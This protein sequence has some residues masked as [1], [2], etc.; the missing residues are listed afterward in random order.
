MSLCA[1]CGHENREGAR[2]CDACG[3]ALGGPVAAGE[4]RKTVTVLFSDVTGSTALGEQLDP[5]S[6]RRVMARYFELARSVIERH[7]GSVEKFIGDAVMAVFGIPMAHEDDAL[8]AVRAAA[9]LRAGLDAL[10]AA[11]VHEYATTL[12]LRIGINT[13]EVVTGTAERLATG[14]AVNVA[15][16][17]EQAAQPGEI[18][19]GE[20]TRS[21]AR[22]AISAERLA[23]LELK[24]KT[25]AVTAY[26]LIEIV[27]D[28]PSRSRGGAMIGRV[29][30]L[31]RLR[32]ALAQAR[33]DG[34][35][36]LFT[37]LG[38]AGVG[39]SRLVDEFLEGLDD[40][41]VARG[42]CLPYGEG[43]TYWP[44]VEVLRQLLGPEPQARLLALGLGPS[45]VRPIQ[46][47]LGDGSLQASAEEI[48]WATRALFEAFASSSPLVVVLDD[49][50]WGEQA[51][52]DLIDHVA[53]LSRDAPI[54]LLCMARPE[55]LDRQQRWG[56]GK[57]NATTV[58]IEPLAPAEAEQLVSGLL[59]D[60]PA[61]AAMR[62]RILEVAEG[63]PLF[64]E[65]MIALLRESPEG[66][67]QVPPTIQ[68]LLAARLDQL[69]PAERLVLERGSVEGRVFHEG[70]VRALAPDAGDLLVPLT[71]LV[72]RELLR[73]ER[74]QVPGEDA[75][76]FRHLLIR[77]AAYDSIPKSTRAALHERFATWVDGQSVDRAEVDELVAYHLERAYRYRIELAPV[78]APARAIAERAAG[79]LAVA[80]TRAAARGDVGAS[81]GLLGR[82]A[83]L[84]PAR[85]PR[86]LAILAPYG[87]ALEEAGQLERADAILSEAVALGI[88]TGARAAAAEAT[89]ARINLRLFTGTTESHDD[90]RR[91]LARAQATFQELGDESGLAHALGLVGQ[92]R[93]W[94]GD[95]TAAIAD[96]DEA[97]RHA[98]KAG[99]RQQELQCLR[100]ALVASVNGPMPVEAALAR[101]A[102]I[103]GLAD[104]DHT[105]VVTCLRCRARL[106]SMLGRFALA[107]SLIE[108][109]L[110]R[111]RTFGLEGVLAATQLDAAEIAMLDGREDAAETA[112]RSAVSSLESMGDQGHLAT[113]AP[114]L[115]TLLI[116]Q[117]RLAEASPM[118]EHAFQW[119]IADD[120]DPQIGWRRAQANLLARQGELEPAEGLL[121]EAVALGERTDFS[122]VH[123]RALDD[124]ADLLLLAGRAREAGEAR[125]TALVLYEQKGNIVAAANTRL[126]L[127][128]D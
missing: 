108:E 8:R 90:A 51:F 82:A 46:S 77:D 7:E 23:P 61:D 31:E 114:V 124:L 86:R 38:A 121:R 55:L 118:I 97:A 93:F 27:A 69:A 63:N 32:A 20:T 6:L 10:N 35:C 88:E 128:L 33:A 72:R 99:N 30:E 84:L 87:R 96:L 44:I 53:S 74:S 92:L 60:L 59:D 40:A 119:I 98:R 49:I 56:G 11:L 123:A 2:F 47:V 104:G 17:L 22:D 111:A 67:V 52:L 48:A 26:R 105:L 21:L 57:L 29:R 16:R 80:G 9:D 120:I 89:V 110:A 75:Y 85:D 64:V 78:D 101:A 13:G 50:H 65:E 122:E 126:R 5:E 39:K 81:I 70:A 12:E 115:A 106:E 3:A 36:Q 45:T 66:S 37:V 62:A 112:L 28:A 34:S 100:Y 41:T 102:E 43:I 117:G 79:R 95:S 19:L 94:A 54:L 73:S 58:L 91:E 107:S 109:A 113:V 24:G 125:A 4:Q 116:S 1:A 103:E 42:T 18:V 127:E 83:E 14:D 71:A 76:R 68:A 15:A 25:A